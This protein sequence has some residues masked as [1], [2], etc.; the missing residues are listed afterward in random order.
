MLMHIYAAK[1]GIYSAPWNLW[2]PLRETSE[3]S[4][5]IAMAGKEATALHTWMLVCSKNNTQ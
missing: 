3:C 4:P 5:L 1:L 2:I